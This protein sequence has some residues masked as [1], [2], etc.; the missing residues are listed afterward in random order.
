MIS[1]NQVQ[2]RTACEDDLPAMRQVA[3]GCFVNERVHR[4]GIVDLLYSRPQVDP[5]L[6]VV[7]VRGDDIVGF[8]FA[9]T[10]PGSTTATGYVDGWAVIVSERLKGVGSALLTEVESRLS[11]A[12]C[13]WVQMGGTTWF[14]AWPGIDL[15]Y[16]AA[17]V[18][19][20]KAGF[21]CQSLVHNMD[22]DLIR[23]VPMPPDA[24]V[25]VRRARASDGPVLHDLIEAHFEAVWQ[26]EV[27]LALQRAHP[28]VHVAE[29]DGRLVGFAAHGVYQ[30]DL[31][32][33]LGTDPAQRGSGIGV[34]LLHACL[35]DM[36]V[37]GLP[38]AQIGWIG[39]AR[40]YARAAGA[41]IGRTFAILRKALGEQAEPPGR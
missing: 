28:T 24:A 23:W 34:A 4:A 22:V 13:R 17:L 14:Y 26:H 9:S 30:P 2:L 12:G 3:A 25:T 31:F 8:V 15:A 36:A 29:R 41:R 16:T 19:A 11:A 10:P 1:L 20:G 35:G 7:A 38:V 39:P 37:A 18:A 5:D 6:R 32:G 27:H 33:P 21:T 40:F